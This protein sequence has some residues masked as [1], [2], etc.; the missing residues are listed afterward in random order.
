MSTKKLFTDRRWTDPPYAI[1]VGKREIST[2]E[3]IEALDFLLE[4]K[5]ITLEE[6]EKQKDELLTQQGDEQ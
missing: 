3:K 2:A 4:R 5:I 6:Y 1:V